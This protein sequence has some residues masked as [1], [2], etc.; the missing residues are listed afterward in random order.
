MGKGGS[1]LLLPII[2]AADNIAEGTYCHE[3]VLDVWE[4]DLEPDEPLQLRRDI[5]GVVND[6]FGANKS[7]PINKTHTA[8]ATVVATVGLNLHYEMLNL[9]QVKVRSNGRFLL[10]I[11]YRLV[12]VW[13]GMDMIWYLVVHPNGNIVHDKKYEDVYCTEGCYV[14]KGVIRGAGSAVGEGQVFEPE[15]V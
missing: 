15:S 7:W 2:K 14:A 6:E 11:T 8:E 12:A 10:R 5:Y 9:R 4:S 13:T 1:R 3:G